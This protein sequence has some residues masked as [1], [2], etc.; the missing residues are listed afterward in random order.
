MEFNV[1][2]VNR[3][4][5]A[6]SQYAKESATLIEENSQIVCPLDH[7]SLR[8]Q[9]AFVVPGA[10]VTGLRAVSFANRILGAAPD[11]ALSDS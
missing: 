11:S 6:A 4:S 7:T 9:L 8:V 2:H 5:N 10:L 1:V 3:L